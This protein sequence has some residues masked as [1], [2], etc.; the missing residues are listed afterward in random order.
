MGGPRLT[1]EQIEEASE[2][3]ART[4]N[5]SEAARAIGVN[6]ST[7][8]AAFDRI[9]IARN[10]E[11]HARACEEGMQEGVQYLR[12]VSQRCHALI[13]GNLTAAAGLEASDFASLGRTVNGA[14]ATIAALA[15]RDEERRQ[16]RLTRV[17][18]R[19]DIA[20]VEADTAKVRAETRALEREGQPTVEQILA[21]LAGLPREELARALDELRARRA[22]AAAPP[23][24][25]GKPEGT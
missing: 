7:L 2:V 24:A 9:R 6:E 14:Q 5:T 1:P 15:K 17:K 22:A 10:R 25:P 19:G 11:L 13:M 20:K 16:A 21:H 23:P 18:T 12:D 4:N 8:R 3:F